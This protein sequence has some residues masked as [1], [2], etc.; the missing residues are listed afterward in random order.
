VQQRLD[1][2]TG[3]TLEE[4]AK[5]AQRGKKRKRHKWRSVDQVMVALATLG[6]IVAILAAV[7][8]WR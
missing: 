4:V 1:P 6:L 8:A 7:A 5:M 3:P 2:Y